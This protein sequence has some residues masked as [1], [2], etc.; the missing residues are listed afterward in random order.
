MRMHH[1]ALVLVGAPASRTRNTGATERMTE[2]VCKCMLFNT[3][4]HKERL[5]IGPALIELHK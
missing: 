5:H 3:M 1:V 2:G 4:G